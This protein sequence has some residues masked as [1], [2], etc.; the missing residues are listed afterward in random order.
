MLVLAVT[1]LVP[2]L[3]SAAV[4]AAALRWPH[5]DPAAPSGAGVVAE[6]AEPLAFLRDLAERGVRSAVFEGGASG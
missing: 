3:V 5:A 6:V 4:G 1:A 2:L